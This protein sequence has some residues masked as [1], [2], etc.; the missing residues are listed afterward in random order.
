VHA[1]PA[2]SDAAYRWAIETRAERLNWITVG[3][4]FDGGMS[5]AERRAARSILRA[6]AVA[7]AD[8]LLTS[9]GS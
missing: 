7:R 4:L 5:W 8:D 9:E 1:D 2:I 3:A 6:E